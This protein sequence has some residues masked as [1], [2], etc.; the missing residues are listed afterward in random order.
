MRPTTE[1]DDYNEELQELYLI[2][3]R[4][5]SELEFLKEEIGFLKKLIFGKTF[6]PLIQSSDLEIVTEALNK[7]DSIV[8]GQSTL[9]Q[10][11][12]DYLEKLKP[13]LLHSRKNYDLS[14]IELHSQLDKK[15][16]E[17][18]FDF[19]SVK[20]MVFDLT[21]QRMKGKSA[22]LRDGK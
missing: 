6:Y 12:M 20:N 18:A 9:Q 7:A 11:I 16:G 19:I 17:L 4:S 8:K 14:L 15:L 1:D 13:Y 5:I 22:E 10:G 3:K 2:S 21:I